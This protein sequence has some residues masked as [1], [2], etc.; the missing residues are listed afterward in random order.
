MWSLRVSL[1]QGELKAAEHSLC[2]QT[3]LLEYFGRLKN[4]PRG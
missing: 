2:R 3:P 4:P 1:L